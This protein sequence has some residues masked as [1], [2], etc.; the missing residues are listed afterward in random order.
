MSQALYGTTD[1]AQLR[2]EI[3]KAKLQAAQEVR[4]E[5]VK[6]RPDSP[7]LSF[8]VIFVIVYD[9]VDEAVLLLTPFDPRRRL[10]T[11]KPLEGVK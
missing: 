6:P 5:I 9:T 11:R 1:T 8:P 2:G 7:D 4:L 10:M 3:D